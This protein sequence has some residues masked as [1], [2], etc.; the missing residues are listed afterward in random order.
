M[1]A[2]LIR[3]QPSAPEPIY[4][5]IADQV[6]RLVASG[7]LQAGDGLPSVRDIAAHHAVNPMTVSKAYSQLET[8]GVLERLR[9]KGMVVAANAVR[10]KPL[11]ERLQQLEPALREVAQRAEELELPPERV[12]ARLRQLMEK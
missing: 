3:I 1:D 8:E 4:R 12:L 9:G 6:R 5:Q 10:P 11:A 7:Q 2:T